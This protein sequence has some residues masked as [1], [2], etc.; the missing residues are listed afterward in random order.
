MIKK[1]LILFILFLLVLGGFGIYGA[2]KSRDEVR[3]EKLTAKAPQATITFVEGWDNKDIANYLQKEGITSSADFLSSVK[4]YDPAKY[5]GILPKEAGGSLEGFLFPDTYFIPAKAGPG[6]NINDI[7]IGKALDNFSQKITPVMLNQAEAQGMSLYQII[8][9]ASII[10]KEAGG[11]QDDRKM[12]AGVFYN[13]LKA[14][15]PLQSDATVSF[16]TGKSPVSSVDTQINSLYNTYKYTGLPPGPI[17]NPG[18]NSILAALYPT[19]NN[20]FYFLTIPGTG[21]AVFAVTYD[22]HLKNKAKYL[23]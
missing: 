20:Y 15:M 22:D 10:E 2:L 9:L 4:N 13:R 1:I 3:R 6:Q 7:I 18:L 23:K 14:G 16:I 17:C 5:K 8:T 12:I 19:D 21:R 11:N